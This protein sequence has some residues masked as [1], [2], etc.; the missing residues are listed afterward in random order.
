MVDYDFAAN[1]GYLA[2][3][4]LTVLAIAFG[5][6][7][8]IMLFD[9]PLKHQRDSQNDLITWIKEGFPSG[10]SNLEREIDEFLKR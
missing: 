5:I 4:I 10:K 6:T 1:I 7:V 3:A 8:I 2:L 9:R